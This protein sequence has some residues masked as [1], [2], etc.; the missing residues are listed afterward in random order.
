MKNYS[1]LLAHGYEVLKGYINNCANVDDAK[2]RILDEG[3]NDIIDSF[4]VEEFTKGYEII[5]I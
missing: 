4:D 1:F 3:Y 2:S 5:D